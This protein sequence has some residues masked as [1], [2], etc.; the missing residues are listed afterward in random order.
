MS[1]VTPT[2]KDFKKTFRAEIRVGISLNILP[3]RST[4]ENDLGSCRRQRK[5]RD[6]IHH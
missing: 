5:L 3:L 2:G 1:N 4:K 6:Q